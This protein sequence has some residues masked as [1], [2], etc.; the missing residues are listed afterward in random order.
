MGDD[1]SKKVLV[2][3]F[4]ENSKASFP[5]IEPSIFDLISIKNIGVIL[6]FLNNIFASLDAKI[7]PKL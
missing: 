1:F 5:I 3:F 2:K 4:K 6:V 7:F